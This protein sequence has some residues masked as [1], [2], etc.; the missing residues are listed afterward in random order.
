M[1]K[2]NIVNIILE[3]IKENMRID[4]IDIN[5]NLFS[6]KY[7]IL[8]LD[9]IYIIEDLEKSINKNITSIFESCN[10][11]I[12]TVNNLGQAIANLSESRV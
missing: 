7:K 12:M 9:M 6:D 10:E 3:V 4:N 2:E 8:P 5:E 1:S 11:N